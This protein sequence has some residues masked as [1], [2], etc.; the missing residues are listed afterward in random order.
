MNYSP[1]FEISDPR[2]FVRRLGPGNFWPNSARP[3]GIFRS[4]INIRIKPKVKPTP[5][6]VKR[7][8][9]PITKRT[10]KSDVT[11]KVSTQPAKPKPTITTRSWR[12]S[13]KAAKQRL[14]AETKPIEKDIYQANQ[15]SISSGND[16]EPVKETG[17]SEKPVSD[18]VG[19]ND[20]ADGI[21]SSEVRGILKD[22]N[23]DEKLAEASPRQEKTE[24]KPVVTKTLKSVR[25][26]SP[27]DEDPVR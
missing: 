2:E 19:I 16:S 5:E 11:R 10:K 23:L 24:T 17:I 12:D 9:K 26:K 20:I 3:V 4:I 27:R 22:L 8:K 21:L 6:P 13:Q 1:V 18:Q 14:K 15:K 7:P 25:K